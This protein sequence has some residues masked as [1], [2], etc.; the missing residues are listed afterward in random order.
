MFSFIT[1]IVNLNCPNGTS[2]SS[3]LATETLPATLTEFVS[4]VG[5]FF[6][7]SWYTTPYNITIGQDN[8]VGSIRTFVGIGDGKIYNETLL[9][10]NLNSS[11]FEQEWMG[12]GNDGAS[13]DFGI[14]ILGTYVERLTGVST[15]N[16]SAVIVNFGSDF[17][18]TNLDQAITVLTGVHA[19][20]IQQIQTLLNVGNFTSC[21]AI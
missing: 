16:G 12:P 1:I 19:Y 2:Q 11:Y 6:N 9:V 14:F 10:Y 8:Q 15:C 20:G 18:G 7:D 4:I 13:I 21:S 5:S 3:N 17:C